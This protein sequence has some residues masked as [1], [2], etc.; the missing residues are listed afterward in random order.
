M[1]RSEAVPGKR[2]ILEMNPELSAKVADISA[3]FGPTNSDAAR[4]S[5][6]ILQAVNEANSSQHP[7][8]IDLGAVQISNKIWRDVELGMAELNAL[9]ASVPQEKS[10]GEIAYDAT[11]LKPGLFGFKVDLK[12]VWAA[13]QDKKTKRNEPDEI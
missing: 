4:T 11:E 1:N 9:P 7:V 2:I 5:M 3:S 13:Y 10:S 6:L 8:L 12:K